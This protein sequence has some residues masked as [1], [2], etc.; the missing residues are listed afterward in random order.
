MNMDRIVEGRRTAYASCAARYSASAT[1][2]SIYGD[3]CSCQNN[4]RAT[5]YWWA[6]DVMARYPINGE[7]C[8][9]QCV[10][11]EFACGV[12]K[13]M[14]PACVE[15]ACGDRP[16]TC[17]IA[18]SLTTYQTADA[19]DQPFLPSVLG[20]TSLIISNVTGVV[21][22][23]SQN[24]GNIATSDGNNGWTYSTPPSGSIIYAAANGLYYVAF[25][26]GAGPL[27]PIING[28]LSG[29]SL[30]LISSAPSVHAV[31]GRQIVIEYS[32]DGVTWFGAY[33]GLESIFAGS[34]SVTVSGTPTLVRARYI[35]GELDCESEVVSG[36]V[37]PPANNRSFHF[38]VNPGDGQIY[39]RL[40]KQSQLF[41]QVSD[42][43]VTPDWTWS[44]W[45][46]VSQY[47]QLN[48]DL[49]FFYTAPANN[50][51]TMLMG[52]FGYGPTTILFDLF[53]D[54]VYCDAPEAF[55]GNWHHIAVTK[56][57]PANDFA[58]LMNMY[59]NGVQKTVMYAGFLGGP[60]YGTT[61]PPLS[62]PPGGSRGIIYPSA[63]ANLV[64]LPQSDYIRMAEIY[65]CNSQR[66][67]SEIQNI[68]MPGLVDTNGNDATWGRTLYLKPIDSDVVGTNGVAAQNFN[69]FAPGQ[70]ERYTFTGR[71]STD[72][73]L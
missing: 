38:D 59:V 34:Y 57:G 40:A 32:A 42:F 12:I 14:D 64:N 26:G 18:Q 16:A 41:T 69:P 50:R 54:V 15:C 43:Y 52:S 45:V 67:Q 25:P 37:P 22:G 46:R 63:L 48:T 73:P 44:M 72:S 53:G 56:V 1:Q 49:C 60:P 13:L 10:T 62:Q 47:G 11:E 20:E 21:N 35:Y 31:A 9:C 65:M 23:F 19:A 17:D 28:S 7:T 24:V 30:A 68:I 27:Y 33:V 61:A 2:D 70:T 5:A 58:G 3:D 71:F 8:D 6:Q 55:D 36:S 51:G 39:G 4:A 66:S 29:T